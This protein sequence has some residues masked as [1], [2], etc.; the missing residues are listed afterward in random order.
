MVID[1]QTEKMLLHH[2]LELGNPSHRMLGCHCYMLASSLENTASMVDKEILRKY[3]LKIMT[4]LLSIY[5]S[6]S[7]SKYIGEFA[8]VINYK[9]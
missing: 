1:S 6:H 5:R 2:V 9:E 4:T 3:S 8:Y 7:F